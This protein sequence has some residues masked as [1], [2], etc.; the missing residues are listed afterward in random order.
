MINVR[1]YKDLDKD[2]WDAYVLN[3]PLCTCYH[4]SGWKNVIE[5]TY[6]HKTYYLLA[7]ESHNEITQSPSDLLTN[8]RRILG[9]LPL[10]H[11]KHFLLGNVL[12]S[13]PFF[14]Y[15]GILADDEDNERRL[16]ESAINI[17]KEV[18]AEHIEL[19]HIH[20]VNLYNPDDS[21]DLNRLTGKQLL[22]KSHKVRMLL[23]LPENSE[24]LLESFKSKLKSQIRKPEKG[25]LK[26]KLGR[27]D[28]IQDFY[29]VFTINMKD[30]GSPVHHISL[31]K[32]VLNEFPNEGKIGVVY[33]DKEP[34]AA[35]LI[36]GFNDT[37]FIPWASSLRRY[38]RLSP[39][40]M[41]YWNFLKYAADNGFKRFDFGR[42]TSGGSTYKFKQQW[43]AKSIPLHW[44]YWVNGKN[45]LPDM[46]S[47]NPKFKVAIKFW[48]KLPVFVTKCLGPYIRK[49]IWL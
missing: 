33:K 13:L 19:R 35:G 12:V 18:R 44:Q 4:L 30:L 5:D 8:D 23:S 22:T 39:N 16:I 11:L 24:I 41:L 29:E 6:G 37:V 3:H 40:M 46:D 1:P 49:Y 7:E 27:L 34:M 38:N 17:A 42:S 25:G 28:L 10:A 15:G 45:G 26:A 36:I 14:D 47:K 31:M 32:N 48:K 20:P 2:S 21:N 9:I 43:G